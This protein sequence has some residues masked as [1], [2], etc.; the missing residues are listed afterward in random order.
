MN[1]MESA[2]NSYMPVVTGD[3]WETQF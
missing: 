2:E 1:I 3:A